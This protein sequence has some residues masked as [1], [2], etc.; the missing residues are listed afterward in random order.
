M[1][2]DINPQRLMVHIKQTE[3]LLPE[4]KKR[5]S[6]KKEEQNVIQFLEPNHEDHVE[7]EDVL[8]VFQNNKGTIICLT[9]FFGRF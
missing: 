2:L 8:N 1:L 5:K 9:K 7:E 3:K 4:N 6:K